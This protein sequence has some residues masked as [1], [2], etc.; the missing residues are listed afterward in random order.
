[1]EHKHTPEMEA[2]IERT[3]KKLMDMPK[4]EL[5]EKLKECSGG[6]IARLY[7]DCDQ[8]FLEEKFPILK[9]FKK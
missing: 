4:D 1:M 5:F 2:A 9:K 6:D 8:A 7:E 3:F